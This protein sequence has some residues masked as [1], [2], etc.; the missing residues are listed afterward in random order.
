MSQSTSTGTTPASPPGQPVVLGIRRG[1]NDDRARVGRLADG[2]LEGRP[3]IE[4]RRAQTEVDERDIL[5]R[6]PGD[7]GFERAAGGRERSIEDLHGEQIGLGRFFVNRRGD[8][9]PVSEP[10]DA[11]PG[12]SSV[13]VERGGAGKT[14]HVRM[15]GVHAAVDHRDPDAPAGPS[16]EGAERQADGP[17]SSSGHGRRGAGSPNSRANAPPRA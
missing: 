2:P 10:I 14:A 15:R 16:R 9:R 3:V 11:V 17:S 1:G 7:S 6:R 12:Q 5:R 8:G 13:I 4:V